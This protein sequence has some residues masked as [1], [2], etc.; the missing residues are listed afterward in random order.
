MGTEQKMLPKITICTPTWQRHDLLLSRCVPS[1]QAQTYES[2]EHVIVSDGPDENL[3]DHFARWTPDRHPVRYFELPGHHPEP[4]FGHYARRAAIDHARGELIGYNDD[5]DSLRPEHCMLMEA[6]LDADPE[7]RF[8]V[9]RMLSHQ[10]QGLLLAIGWGPLS[11]G[12]V[13]TPMLMHR[14]GLLGVATWGPPSQL[15]DWELVERWLK[16][17]VPYCNVDADTADVWPS[18]FR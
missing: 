13:G 1:I 2:V 10:A 7:A 18:L 3:R 6:A 15:E 14:R 8:A 12:N 11:C 9:S 4:N 5:D 17:G 16:A